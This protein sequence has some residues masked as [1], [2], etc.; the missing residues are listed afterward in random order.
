MRL[1]NRKK[2]EAYA[3]W[4]PDFRDISRLPDTKPIRT[5][6]IVNFVAIIL[7]AGLVGTYAFREYSL[8]NVSSEVAYLREQV[9]ENRDRNKALVRLNQEFLRARKIAEEAVRFD[10]EPLPVPR[11]LGTLAE[12]LPEGIVLDSIE[13]RFLPGEGG[14]NDAYPPFLIQLDGSVVEFEASSPSR[15]L[16]LLQERLEQFP[17]LRGRILENDLSQFNRNNELDVFDFS[18]QIRL[19]AGEESAS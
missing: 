5:G 3:P 12:S 1:K 10:R 4:R 13:M 18:V 19:D 7:A 6:F 16:N 15:I 9:D 8:Y 11:F 17:S 14:K 2:T